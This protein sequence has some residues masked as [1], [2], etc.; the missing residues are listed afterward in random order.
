MRIGHG[1]IYR[2]GNK[3]WCTWWVG[4]KQQY[5]GGFETKTDAQAQ[6]AKVLNAK[7][8]GQPSP[9]AAHKLT[10]AKLFGLV[11]TDYKISNKKS[12]SE[13][14]RR[15]EKHLIP[16][17]GGLKVSE[18]NGT[19][20]E[21]Y[22]KDRLS[23]KSA[24]ADVNRDLAIIRRSYSLAVKQN[25]L[26][27]KLHFELLPEKNIRTLS[28]KPPEF[29]TLCEQLPADILAP[30][31]FQWETGWRISEVV[32]LEWPQIDFEEELILLERYS[33]KSGEPR[34]F[35]FTSGLRELLK[36]QRETVDALQKQHDKIIP[37]VFP[38]YDGAPL[39]YVE[40]TGKI[41]AARYFYT[42]WKR[43]TK[44]AELVGMITHD[45]RRSAAINRR[46]AGVPDDLNMALG[47][48]ETRVML[49][50][51]LGKKRK[52][53]LRRATAMIDAA[54]KQN[55]SES[56]TQPLQFK[57]SSKIKKTVNRSK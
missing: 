8:L 41:H 39:F 35:P 33:T 46:N 12:T 4:G 27:F 15:I 48:W 31:K 13:V 50:R 21:D 28:F 2:R 51:Y 38:K 16:F 43:G 23:K 25:L 11:E 34:V 7:S 29:V 6:L 17:F 1:T 57:G 32:T 42:Q 36:A 9:A 10:A 22:K 52:E 47:G 20:I 37:Y 54:T 55:K 3:W 45:L 18:I 40:Q 49:D 26:S 56:I 44:A 14:A 30:V 53:D 19:L 24:P 5:T